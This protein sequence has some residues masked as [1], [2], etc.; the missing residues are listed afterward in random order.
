MLQQQEE[1]VKQQD[2]SLVV[3]AD[4]EDKIATGAAIGSSIAATIGGKTGILISNIFASFA[5][6]FQT[7]SSNNSRKK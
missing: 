1:Q 5:A 6:L 4:T 7:L 3:T 2:E